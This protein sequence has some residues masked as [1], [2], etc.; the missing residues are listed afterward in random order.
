MSRY[1][2]G[3]DSGSYDD[4]DE[5]DS[6]GDDEEDP[7]QTPYSR[8]TL[9]ARSDASAFQS[10]TPVR[11][12][13]PTPPIYVEPPRPPV[14]KVSTPQRG[15]VTP[16][17]HERRSNPPVSESY[18]RGGKWLECVG[19]ALAVFCEGLCGVW[20]LACVAAAAMRDAL[21]IDAQY[22][23]RE[24]SPASSAVRGKLL[25]IVVLQQLL[26][27]V[28]LGLLGAVG[29]TGPLAEVVHMQYASV[30]AAAV[31][32]V[33]LGTYVYVFGAV[34]PSQRRGD[35][36]YSL[37]LV[38]EL[39]TAAGGGVNLVRFATAYD[40]RHHLAAAIAPASVEDQSEWDHGV[41]GQPHFIGAFMLAS[42]AVWVV[43]SGLNA[44]ALMGRNRPKVKSMDSPSETHE[45]DKTPVR[46]NLSSAREQAD[47]DDGYDHDY[48]NPRPPRRRAARNMPPMNA[49]PPRTTGRMVVQHT[50]PPPGL[51]DP[52]DVLMDLIANED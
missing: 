1:D 15:P 10:I 38:V 13:P 41:C 31:V 3:D 12:S 47:D 40:D 36:V 49:G 51:V 28:Q 16:L 34:D 5:D 42:S 29:L 22:S 23:P 6:L 11:R 50:G 4:D 39:A 45:Q 18:P 35:R 27:G 37:Y 19:R 7:Q 52:D 33:L 17:P 46:V 20:E 30:Q 21:S 26:L 9:D 32:S 24:D 25:V 2:S 43:L 14:Q 8:V 44:V 48:R